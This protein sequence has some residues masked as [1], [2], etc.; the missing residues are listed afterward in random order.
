MSSHPAPTSRYERYALIFDP[1]RSR[2]GG[3][4]LG[5]VERGID[6]LYASDVDE[7]HLMA[8]QEVGRVG[9]LVVP[10]SLTLGEVD[11]LL[12]RI[13]PQLWA[14]AAAVVVVGPAEER[15]V[16]RGLADRGLRWI[17]R[18]PY[19]AAEFRFVVSAALSAEDKLDPRGGLRVPIS[20]NVSV[21]H[22][23][24]EHAGIVRNVSIGGAYVALDA[25]PPPGSSIVLSLGLG[26]QPLVIESS[27]VYCQGP[28]LGRAVSEQGMGVA[29]RSL[30]PEAR[31]LLGEFIEERIRSFRL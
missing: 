21:A 25:T 2:L 7:A 29:F 3:E 20:M 23:G 10:G 4:A 28:M 8:L 15:G 17:L 6:P 9:A 26:D 31:A 30:A 27:V 19:D 18:E 12:D 24:V 11:V 16:L 14:G 5:L 1:D 22:A 13:A